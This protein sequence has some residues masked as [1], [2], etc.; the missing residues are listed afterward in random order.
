MSCA[1]ILVAC[2]NR[3]QG[4]EVIL[5]WFSL[6][7]QYKTAA[8]DRQSVLQFTIWWTGR[9]EGRIN[10]EILASAEFYV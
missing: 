3:A 10:E 7:G 6:K 4:F 9:G 5:S 2:D 8:Q 1:D